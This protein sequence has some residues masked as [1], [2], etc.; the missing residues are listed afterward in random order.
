MSGPTRIV[1]QID[2]INTVLDVIASELTEHER[3]CLRAMLAR[4]Q[5]ILE[6]EGPQTP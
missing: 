1:D 6:Q 5:A 3:D 2:T 4:L